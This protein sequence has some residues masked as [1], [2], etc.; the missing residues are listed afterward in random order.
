M[1]RFD[2]QILVRELVTFDT[3]LR[4]EDRDDWLRFWFLIKDD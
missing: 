4:V 2:W 1:L 3:D